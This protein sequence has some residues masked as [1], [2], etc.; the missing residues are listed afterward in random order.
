MPLSRKRLLRKAKRRRAKFNGHPALSSHRLRLAVRV[1]RIFG[2]VVTATTDGQH[3]RNS[4]HYIHRAVDLASW[5]K[6][7]MKRA[8]LAIRMVLGKR[9]L[10]ELFG[11]A[12]WYVKNG[13]VYR[14]HF[15]N[16][17]DHV[18]VAV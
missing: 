3:A 12:G 14:G 15:P 8:Q 9:N 4:Y 5:N 16:H 2:L 10:K 11:P 13:R 7:R 1:G 6:R 17:G 18:H